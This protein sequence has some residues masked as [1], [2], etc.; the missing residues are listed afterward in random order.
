MNRYHAKALAIL[1]G[2]ILALP[3]LAF[4][5]HLPKIAVSSAKYAV[6]DEPDPNDGQSCYAY[7]RLDISFHTEKKGP[8]AVGMVVTD[9]R[10]RRVGFDPIKNS[11]WQE[12]PQAEGFI[13][14][15]APDGEGECRGIIQVCGPLSGTYKLEII[16]QQTAEYSVRVDGRS[17][18]VRGRHGLQSSHSAAELTDVAIRKG[19]RD[20]L[21]LSYSRDLESKMTFQ[22]QQPTPV[23]GNE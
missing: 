13:D 2:G 16:A 10:G 18:E 8:P 17:E 5:W 9:P 12:L 3:L 4:G 23:A 14:C 15:D 1:S 22:E 21:L 11:A 6:H 7:G 19:S 20:T